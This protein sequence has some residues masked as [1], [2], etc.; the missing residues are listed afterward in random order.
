MMQP[1]VK[2]ALGPRYRGRPMTTQALSGFEAWTPGGMIEKKLPAFQAAFRGLDQ[3]NLPVAFVQDILLTLLKD[4]ISPFTTLRDQMLRDRR[5]LGKTSYIAAAGKDGVDK[6]WARGLLPV[7][8]EAKEREAK[9]ETTM[10]VVIPTARTADQGISWTIARIIID[11][12]DGY[13]ELARIQ[14]LQPWF[15]KMGIVTDAILGFLTLAG[16]MALRAKCALAKVGQKLYEPIGAAKSALD[17]TMRISAGAG[18]AYLLYRYR[19]PGESA[20]FP[21]AVGAGVT[22]LLLFLR[23]KPPPPGTC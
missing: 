18:L 15:L 9:G 11:I 21:L 14:E 1:I 23:K 7:L 16:Q 2:S 3:Q 19:R 8:L 12:A 6:Y 10:K 22:A 17:L 5:N 13:N 20:M 4:V